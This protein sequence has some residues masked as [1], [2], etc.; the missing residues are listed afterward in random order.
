[1]NLDYIKPKNRDNIPKCLIDIFVL[2]SYRVSQ[3]YRT[4]Y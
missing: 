3:S 1:M 2:R 4:T